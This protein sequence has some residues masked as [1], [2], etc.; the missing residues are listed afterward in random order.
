MLKI[1]IE[2]I[3][4]ESHRYPTVGDWWFVE[5]QEGS[6]EKRLEVRVSNMGNW[7]YEYLVAMHEVDEALLCY[8]RG[9]PE[10]VVSDFDVVFEKIRESFPEV[11]GDQEPGD[12]VSAPY[13]KE[14]VFATKIERL[15]AAEM[16]VSWDEYN[17]AVED[18]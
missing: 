17:D 4:H 2:T 1:N 16:G 10:K 13:N 6:E 9:I 11:I 8:A 18:L 14:H 7:K 12:M 5:P 3:P 15:R